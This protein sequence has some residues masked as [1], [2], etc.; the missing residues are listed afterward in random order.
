MKVF[1]ISRFL[2][3]LLFCIFS[4][5][6]ARSDAPETSQLAAQITAL[7]TQMMAQPD[8]KE[9]VFYVTRDQRDAVLKR[10]LKVAKADFAAMRAASALYRQIAADYYEQGIRTSGIEAEV[11]ANLYD[12]LAV[13]YHPENTQV[14]AEL[15]AAADT[16]LLKTKNEYEG[17]APNFA[18]AAEWKED[19]NKASQK[20]RL[21]L[22]QQRYQKALEV[23]PKFA[24]AQNNIGSIYQQLNDLPRANDAFR[25]AIALDPQHRVAHY[26]LANSYHKLGLEKEALSSADKALQFAASPE[27][28]KDILNSRAQIRLALGDHAGAT[29]DWRA[30]IALDPENRALGLIWSNIGMVALADADVKTAQDAFKN[31]VDLAPGSDM[32]QTL[33]AMALNAFELQILA[34]I[35]GVKLAELPADTQNELGKLASQQLKNVEPILGAYRIDSA[36]LEYWNETVLNSALSKPENAPLLRR[37][38]SALNSLTPRRGN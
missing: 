15:V 3:A 7:Q 30:Q 20:G 26:N 16:M 21:W 22:A 32:F 10:A 23:D 12:S 27:V 33:Y 9:R 13:S 24:D 17:A 34:E 8:A 25:A 37:C 6:P 18:T 5:T 19:G 2:C 35:R 38:Q 14:Q 11:T 29:E 31:S 28:K 4:G 36:L 1:K